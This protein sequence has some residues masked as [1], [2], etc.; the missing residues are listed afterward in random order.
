VNGRGGFDGDMP[1]FPRSARGDVPPD[2]D[3]AFEALL[4][5]K[6]RPE[7]AAV[8]LRPLADAIAALT[9]PPMHSEITAEP[10]ARETYRA[11]F[12]RPA[13]TTP[14]PRHRHRHHRRPAFTSLVSVRLAAA[15]VVILAILATAAYIG[16]LPAP[17]QRLAH[18]TFGAPGPHQTFHVMPSVTPDRSPS[19]PPAAFG[20]CTAYHRQQA[21]GK[22]NPKSVVFT[23]LARMAG[24]PAKVPAYCAGVPHPGQGPP[25]KTGKTPPGQVGQTPPGHGRGTP[26][27]QVGKTPP[28]HGGGTPPGQVDQTPP[29]QVGQT[30]PGQ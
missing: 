7:E 23:R 13:D 27:G 20:L 21:H 17:I 2:G 6:L 24:G 18:T 19:L 3:A 26:P 5:G 28:G 14:L 22:I 29:G 9:V 25:P 12:A 15:S 1:N 16:M 30:P 10:S 8:G 4:A 11:G